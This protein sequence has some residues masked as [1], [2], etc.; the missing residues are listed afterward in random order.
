MYIQKSMDSYNSFGQYLE[1]VRVGK[2]IPLRIFDENGLSSRTFQRIV[3]GESDIKLS[4]LS[5]LVE[6]LSIPPFESTTKLMNLSKTVSYKKKCI[7]LIY[8]S[9]FSESSKLIYEFKDYIKT[10]TY[11][12]G[13]EEALYKVLSLDY[14][15]NPNS[16]VTKDEIKLLELKIYNRIQNVSIYTVYDLDFLSYQQI[17]NITSG[18]TKL[19]LKVLNSV[20][21]EP[22]VD[23]HSVQIVEQAM[24]SIF[25][26]SLK[27]NN[28]RKFKLATEIFEN[29]KITDNN[30]YMFVWKK[31]VNFLKLEVKKDDFD[32]IKFKQFKNNILLAVKEIAPPM[33]S[34]IIIFHFSLIETYLLESKL[35]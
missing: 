13:K 34:R 11:T 31:I 15:F 3:K 35:F 25:L 29:Y 23:I 21:K 14:L 18:D 5:L 30:W 1:D 12:I 32:I 8:E 27:R 7:T 19:F 9:K 33:Q 17:N 10:S 6:I 20:N 16:E 22:L 26:E 24:I 4:D 28:F 2:N